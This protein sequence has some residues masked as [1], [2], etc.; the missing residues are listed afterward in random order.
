M[1][2]DLNTKTKTM[3]D[4][5][6][7]QLYQRSLEG[8]REEKTDTQKVKVTLNLVDEFVGFQDLPETVSQC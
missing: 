6:Q 8:Q 3:F 5:I 2:R 1:E 7:V 4:S